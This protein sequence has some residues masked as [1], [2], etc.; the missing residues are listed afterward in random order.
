[1]TAVLLLDQAGLPAGSSGF[2][3]TD[4]L[5]TGALVTVQ[6]VGVATTHDARILTLDDADTT[7]LSSFTQTSMAPPTWTFSPT[8]GVNGMI[9]IELVT[10][11]GLASEDRQVRVFGIRDPS[12]CLF[13]TF[14]LVADPS[15]NLPDLAD[16]AKQLEFIRANELNEPTAKFPNGNPFGWVAELN[17][18]LRRAADGAVPV[19]GVTTYLYSDDF[20]EG[21]RAA[22]ADG[23]NRTAVAVGGTVTL[24]DGTTDPQDS[25]GWGWAT[26][27]VPNAGGATARIEL[28]NEIIVPRAADP[29]IFRAHLLLPSV[30]ADVTPLFGMADAGDLS[31]ARIFVNAAGNWVTSVQSANGGSSNDTVRTAAVAG[32]VYDVRIEVTTGA[33]ARFFVQRPGFIEEDLGTEST[34]LTVPDASDPMGL[35]AELDRVAGVGM[36]SVDWWDVRGAR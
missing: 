15:A 5:D 6:S 4:G 20:A 14:G 35:F 32:D 8:V 22:A 21:L 24:P 31:Y 17:R 11:R 16:S 18:I 10:D 13:P 7:S 1:M 9:R 3:R 2:A 29:T 12:G 19:P 23:P 25:E 33:S 26:L 28:R 36:M 27:T 34:A 30:F